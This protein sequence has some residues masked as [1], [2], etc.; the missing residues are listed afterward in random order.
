MKPLNIAK[1]TPFLFFLTFGCSAEQSVQELEENKALVAQCTELNQFLAKVGRENNLIHDNGTITAKTPVSFHF[2]HNKDGYRGVCSD[3]QFSFD[4]SDLVG[5]IAQQKY[6][7][8]QQGGEGFSKA[9]KFDDELWYSL[10]K[11]D[12]V[13]KWMDE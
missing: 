10:V 7:F 1:I 13:K 4:G 11:P 2:V 6:I 8:I 9:R 5:T 12:N 3:G